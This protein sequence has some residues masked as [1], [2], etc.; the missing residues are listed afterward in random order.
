M[1]GKKIWLASPHMIGNEMK[2][3]EDAIKSN[4]ITT[5][6]P[7]VNRLEQDICK[8]VGCRSGAAVSS[9]TAAIHLALIE[10]GVKAGDIVFCSD[11]TFTASANPI[12]YCGA[13]PVFIDSEERTAGM[14]PDALVKAFKKYKAKA[15][16]VASIYGIPARLEDIREICDCYGAVMIEDSTEALGSTIYG[17]HVGTVGK[18]GTY[19]FNGNK[20]I[21]TSGGGI[22]VSHDENSVSHAR[23]LA[24]QAKDKSPFYEHSELGYN[25][26]MSN[27]AAAIGVAQLETIAVK[28]DMKKRIYDMYDRCFSKYEDFGIHMMKVP[29]GST[30]NYWLSVLV[31]EDRSY[32]KPAQIVRTLAEINAEARHVWK[33][34]HTQ[35]LWD[36]C[37]FVSVHDMPHSDWYFEHA[38]C[39]PSDTN[40][41]EDDQY[42]IC[43]KI[44]ESIDQIISLYY[45]KKA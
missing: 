33:P 9:G 17:K 29:A 14:S 6:G 12:R 3:V 22:L 30:S 45:G 19:S 10:A 7:Y 40:M 27:I 4:W 41:T 28:I 11:M 25:Y 35:K 16:V 18:Y 34:L 21:T 36:G 38:V 15:V 37:D 13:T 20:V 44:C 42:C 2:Y 43:M 26:R 24:A 31:M 32:V 23:F 8:Y 5:L 39:L 1:D